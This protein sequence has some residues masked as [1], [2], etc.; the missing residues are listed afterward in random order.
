MQIVAFLRSIDKKIGVVL[1][2]HLSL[3][4]IAKPIQ[5]HGS[6]FYPNYFIYRGRKFFYN[7]ITGIFRQ[8]GGRRLNGSLVQE[9]F[10]F[11]INVK[12]E[13]FPNGKVL[14]DLSVI[15]FLWVNRRTRAKAIVCSNWLLDKTG[16]PGQSLFN[17]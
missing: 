12:S 14:I 16:I 5:L 6:Q 3:P 11:Q 1:D 8:C 2:R 15:T 4:T 7:Q 10:T 9:T 13:Y 17:Y